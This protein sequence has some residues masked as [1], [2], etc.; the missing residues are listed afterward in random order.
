MGEY[1]ECY[2]CHKNCFCE[3]HHIVERSHMKS[4]E[5]VRLNFLHLCSECHRTG[6]HAV[7]KDRKVDLRYKQDLQFKLQQI[8][9]NDYYNIHQI[10]IALEISKSEAEKLC[11]TLHI[12]KEG[13]SSKELIVHMMGDRNYL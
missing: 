10:R 9:H 3:I 2:E 8:F 6:K 7:H 1:S 13:Y 5:N 4:M 12:Y 11:R